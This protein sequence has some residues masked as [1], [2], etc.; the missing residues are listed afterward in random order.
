VDPQTQHDPAAALLLNGSALVYVRGADDGA[1]IT[2]AAKTD[3]PIS[4]V[5]G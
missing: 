3:K 4:I 1:K 5:H 2:A